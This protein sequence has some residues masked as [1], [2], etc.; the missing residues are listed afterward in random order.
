MQTNDFPSFTV[1]APKQINDLPSPPNHQLTRQCTVPTPATDEI[2]GVG[3]GLKIF[4]GSVV[5]AGV[6]HA[7]PLFLKPLH[8]QF[9]IL[10][11]PINAALAVSRLFHFVVQMVR[12]PNKDDAHFV[13]FPDPV[14][15]VHHLL[16]VTLGVHV[17]RRWVQYRGT[18]RIPAIAVA[19]G[20][21]HIA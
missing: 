19:F 11:T 7:D 9:Q 16:V 4:V 13:L 15:R 1:A 17:R 3:H 20:I 2:I 5:V 12:V 10:Q 21:K 8:H 14:V 6:L 18:P